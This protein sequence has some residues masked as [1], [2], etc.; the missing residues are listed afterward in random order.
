MG[1]L[2]ALQKPTGGVQGIVAWDILRQQVA[3][4]VRQKPASGK[5]R[6]TVPMCIVHPGGVRMH[7][8]MLALQAL[9]DQHPQST[10]FSVDD[11]TI[12]RNAM[13]W[14]TW[15][16]ERPFCLSFCNSMAPHP[17]NSGRTD[18]VVHDLQGGRRAGR[19]M[20]AF[21][22]LGQHDPLIAIQA[23]LKGSSRSWMTSTCGTRLP[24]S[25][26]RCTQRCMEKSCC[27]L[28][29]KRPVVS[30]SEGGKPGCHRVEG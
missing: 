9:T 27:G 21:F 28:C 19:F 2:T 18:G 26:P 8:G 24:K 30:C 16:A 20:L 22:A 6:S 29:W 17:L 15:R 25:W 3:R 13:L 1:R 10:I 5:S 4:T 11:E 7:L 23:R 12:S 14:I